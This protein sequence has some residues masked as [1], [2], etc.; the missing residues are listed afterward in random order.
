MEIAGLLH[1]LGRMGM[2]EKMRDVPIKGLSEKEIEI[3]SDQTV[4][5]QRVLSPIERLA[6]VGAMIRSHLEW[7]DGR[8]FPDGLKGDAIP[9]ESKILCVA[10]AYDEVKNRRRFKQSRPVEGKSGEELA[11]AHLKE[12][13]GKT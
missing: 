11:L 2:P 9:L 12:G 7:L 6:D 5:T 3:L 10:N 1:D 13:A 8:R 4:M